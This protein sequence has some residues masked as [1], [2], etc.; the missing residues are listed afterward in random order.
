LPASTLT[1]IPFYQPRSYPRLPNASYSAPA[2]FVVFGSISGEF[3]ASLMM[4]A[5]LTP[6]QFCI[7]PPLPFCSLSFRRT[8]L[9]FQV[10]T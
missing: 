2:A 5:M 9:L 10:S 1:S 4:L 8:R 3:P 6:L 7:S